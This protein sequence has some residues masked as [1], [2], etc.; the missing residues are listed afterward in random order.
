MILA[1]CTAAD[2][3][4]P[5]MPTLPDNLANPAASWSAIDTVLLDMDGTLLDLSFDNFFWLEWVPQKYGE[6]RGLTLAAAQAELEPKFSSMRGRLEWYCTDYW[7]RVL[8]LDIAAMKRDVAD[9]VAWLPGAREFLSSLRR[10]EKR[11]ILVTNAHRDSL[12]IKSERTGLAQYFDALVSSHEYGHAKEH[13]EFWPALHAAHPFDPT[14]T[15][16]AD[17]SVPVLRAARAHGIAFVVRVTHPDTQKEI[18]ICDEF[19][20]VPRIAELMPSN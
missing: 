15:L 11:L 10:I 14:R 7:S 20:S 6:A 16:F 13:A 12:R 9:R 1:L 2:A 19:V 18:G 5:I 17:D 4:F 3:I 8:D